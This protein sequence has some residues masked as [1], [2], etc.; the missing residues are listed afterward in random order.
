MIYIL[1]VFLAI[2]LLTFNVYTNSSFVLHT[3]R[4]NLDF[5]HNL[6]SKILD[7]FFSIFTWFGSLWIIIPLF[8]TVLFIL[9]RNSFYAFSFYLSIGFLG[10]IS[11]TYSLKYILAKKRP[12][13]YEVIG[14]LPKD[15]S[16]PSAHTTQIVIFC[17]L[18]M[19]VISYLELGNRYLLISLLIFA[20]FVV[21]I[22]RMYLQVHF[23]SDVIGGILIALFW[24]L[25]VFYFLSQKELL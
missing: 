7:L 20:M 25:I 13:V 9:L 6:Q 8:V 11:T 21:A 14:E 18:M 10:A 19:L 1:L 4:V 16:F 3:D 2:C 15:P 24:Y 17:L 12:E 23:L 5:F 22:S